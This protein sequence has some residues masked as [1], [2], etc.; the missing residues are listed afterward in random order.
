MRLLGSAA[1]LF[2]LATPAL[3]QDGEVWRVYPVD[4]GGGSIAALAA[5]EVDLP[6][7]IGGSS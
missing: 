3:A 1:M 2:V 5:A 4:G 7:P 6:S